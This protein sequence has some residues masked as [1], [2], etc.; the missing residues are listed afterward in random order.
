MNLRKK[1]VKGVSWTITSQV[2][3]LLITITVTAILARLLNPSDFGIVAMVLVF[4][5]FFSMFNDMG[6]ASAIIQKR[7]VTEL[8]LSSLFWI[9]LIEGLFVSIIFLT[10]APLIAT[11]Y[12]KSIIKPIVM[13]MSSLFTITSIGMVQRALFS[14]EMEFK[15]LSIIEITAAFLSGTVAVVLASIGCGVWSIVAQSLSQYFILSVLLFIFSNW[16]PKFMFKWQPIV[17][18]LGFGIP[19]MGFNLVNYFS[20]N[21]DNM[22]IGRYLG[23]VQLGYYDVAYKSLLFPLSNISQVAGRVMFPALSKLDD[24]KERIR[25]AYI[26]ATR[27]IALVTFPI[28]AGLAI[29]APQFVRVILGSKWEKAIFL[30]QIFALIG[31]LQSLYTTTGWIYLVRGRTGVLF[32]AGLAVAVVYATSFVIGLRWNVEGVAISYAIA[33]LLILL[34]W[35]LVPFRL[36]EMKMWY[37]VKQFRGII[38]ATL[39]MALLLLGLKLFFE[40]CFHM[41]DL[42]LLIVLIL[43]G[44][45]IYIC[46]IFIIDRDI[47][48]SSKDIV[49]NIIS[50]Y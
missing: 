30:V 17:S 33:F 49:N 39:G 18:F 37:Y 10:L 41:G 21:L 31:G 1:T 16:K 50:K 15:K 40:R 34:P 12:S 23:S 4:T 42:A 2:L 3:R 25:Q 43:V 14:K 19:L 27:Y 22:L 48:Y 8:Q 7:D 9:N 32:F 5:N 36:I 29:L 47:I 6:L 13:V 20:R 38:F 11:F 45:I 35:Y 26:Q 44:T 24:E 46:L 28:T